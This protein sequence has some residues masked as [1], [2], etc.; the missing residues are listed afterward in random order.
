MP[1]QSKKKDKDHHRQ[2]DGAAPP[3][4][5]GNATEATTAPSDAVTPERVST[6]HVWLFP[7]ANKEAKWIQMVRQAFDEDVE[8]SE[9][10]SQDGGDQD[11]GGAIGN[12]ERQVEG[13]VEGHLEIAADLAPGVIMGEGS[14]EEAEGS[15]DDDESEDGT[16]EKLSV[17]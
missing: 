17:Q 4:P 1:V 16:E 11:A 12:G 2:N 6:S 7:G 3:L 14:D 13:T 8:S 5:V 10:G 9:E 15:E